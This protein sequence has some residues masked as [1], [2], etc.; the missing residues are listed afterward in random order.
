MYIHTLDALAPC[1]EG[2]CDLKLK[3]NPQSRVLFGKFLMW[4]WGQARLE[5]GLTNP[6]NQTLTSNAN[7]VS[8]KNAVGD[9]VLK[10][11]NSNSG[12]LIFYKNWQPIPYI[13]SKNKMERSV[14]SFLYTACK[15]SEAVEPPKNIKAA[16]QKA[17]SQSHLNLLVS[18]MSP[19]SGVR[20]NETTGFTVVADPLARFSSGY[21]VYLIPPVCMYCIYKY[22]V[23]YF[24]I[25]NIYA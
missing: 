5:I 15:P 23:E 8:F 17:K 25:L 6:F 22:N 14:E 21:Q 1:I 16:C 24:Q 2:N 7:R 12:A 13:R 18:A 4:C 11:F 20:S 3:C 10:V 9:V 19:S